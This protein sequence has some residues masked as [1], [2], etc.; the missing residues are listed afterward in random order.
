MEEN[1]TSWDI[2]VYFLFLSRGHSAQLCHLQP[3]ALLSHSLCHRH[4]HTL[5]GW[6]T[7]LE[8]LLLKVLGRSFPHILS[9]EIFYNNCVRWLLIRN[10][11]YLL[12]LAVAPNFCHPDWHFWIQTNNWVGPTG[13]TCLY[14]KISPARFKNYSG[15]LMLHFFHLKTFQQDV[16]VLQNDTGWVFLI[17]K[18][19]KTSL[20]KN[21]KLNDKNHSQRWWWFVNVNSKT[22]KHPLK[23]VQH[24]WKKYTAAL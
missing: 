11:V 9:F 20:S 19:N 3:V 18:T 16:C 10:K 4:D 8:E 24:C 21:S 6:D 14:S 22:A 15:K 2:S 1:C 5:A 12:P 13:F 17:G 23:F 7:S